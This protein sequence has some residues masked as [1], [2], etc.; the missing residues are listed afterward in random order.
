MAEP[1]LPR[2]TVQA[3]LDALE[4]DGWCTIGMDR[5][6]RTGLLAA[7]PLIDR[8]IRR[9]VAREV[10]ALDEAEHTLARNGARNVGPYGDAVL[11]LRRLARGEPLP[12]ARDLRGGSA[13][14]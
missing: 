1:K 11:S 8:H 9:H 6:V 12:D 2:G 13:D 10:L 4:E 14:G 7:L 5:P 3:V